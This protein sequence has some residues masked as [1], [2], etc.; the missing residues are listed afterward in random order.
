MTI[1]TEIVVSCY[2]DN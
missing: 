2:N 1:T